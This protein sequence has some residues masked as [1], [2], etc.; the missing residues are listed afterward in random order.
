MHA[1]GTCLELDLRLP[2]II[3]IQKT[4]IRLKQAFGFRVAMV[5]G[6]KI[7]LTSFICISL[8]HDSM[9]F[10]F[11]RFAFLVILNADYSLS[12]ILCVQKARTK[13]QEHFFASLSIVGQSNAG[14]LFCLSR[15]DCRLT[16][17]HKG[18]SR[19]CGS[20]SDWGSSFDFNPETS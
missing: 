16:D 14:F 6:S 3:L 18:S 12:T 13:S 5:T 19:R 20:A 7:K 1:I 11:E 10:T 17:G 4:L 2:Q 8:E 15:L 9:R